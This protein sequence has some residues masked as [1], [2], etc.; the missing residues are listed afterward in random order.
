MHVTSLIEPPG[1]HRLAHAAAGDQARDGRSLA[2]ALTE[3]AVGLRR[4]STDWHE[5]LARLVPRAPGDVSVADR[6]ARA[7][8]GWPGAPPPSYEQLAAMLAAVHAASG[9]LELAARRFD[10]AAAVVERAAGR[11]RER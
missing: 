6:Y 10:D 5:A 7:R 3:F 8:A 2:S 9:A 11:G 1:E 4:A